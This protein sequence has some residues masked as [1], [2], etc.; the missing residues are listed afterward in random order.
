VGHA[1]VGRSLV[2]LGGQN[3]IE[4]ARLGCA[5]AVGPHVFNFP[6]AVAVLEGAGGLARVGD[7][8][9]LGEWVAGMIADPGRAAAMGAAGQAAVRGAEGLPGRVAGLLLELRSRSVP[10]IRR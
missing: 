2:P 8:R 10:R 3:P 7:A 1:F 5:V 6:E 9:A 4:P